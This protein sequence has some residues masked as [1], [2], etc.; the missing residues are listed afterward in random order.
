MMSGA[1]RDLMIISGNDPKNLRKDFYFT[2]LG[3]FDAFGNGM[4]SSKGTHSKK[5]RIPNRQA[6][7]VYDEILTFGGRGAA[8]FHFVNGY[9]VEFI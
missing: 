2:N 6:G 5:L 9:G 4:F 3:I 1:A 7:K 8:L